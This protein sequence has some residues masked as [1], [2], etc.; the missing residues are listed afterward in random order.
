MKVVYILGLEHSGTTLT[1]QLLSGCS[2]VVGLGEVAGYFSLSH[3]Q[4]YH[5][6]WGHLPDAYQCSCGQPFDACVFW[7]HLQK[8]SG[9]N[10]NASV[11]ASVLEKYDC[12]VAT[13]KNLYGE[14]TVLVDSSKSINGLKNWLQ[15][16]AHTNWPKHH[17]SV[18]FAVKDA[19]S[20]VASMIR[21]NPPSSSLINIV[22]HFNY[23]VGAN[24]E[25][26]RY[27]AAE[28][29]DF[30]LSLYEQLC[31][32]PAAVLARISSGVVDPSQ[33]AVNIDHNDSHIG[34]GNKAF[35]MRNRK[36]IVYDDSWRAHKP[37]QWLYA[38]HPKAKKLNRQLYST[39]NLPC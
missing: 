24:Q 38:M 2:G 29:I 25:L 10:S 30:H 26:Q 11:N 31:A 17:I 5:E 28:Q 13:A 8:Y 7:Q 4:H 35:I 3:M 16:A 27:L 39:L 19:R 14:E 21:K 22:R 18:V 32:E 23:W 33:L 6:R 12:L 37:L 36:H 15:Y 34:I 1:D 20:F 9:R